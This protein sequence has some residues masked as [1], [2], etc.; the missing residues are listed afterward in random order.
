MTT[1]WFTAAA[2]VVLLSAGVAG[3]STTA[4]AT[5]NGGADSTTA[6]GVDKSRALVQLVGDPI[7]TA[8]K[9]KPAQG[10]KIDWAGQN[11]RSYRAELSARRNEFKRWLRANAPK[12][13][14]TGE[15]DTSL[16]A[17]S[18]ELNGTSLDVLRGSPLAARVEFQGVYSPTIDDPD[19]AII[20]A[21]DA[22]AASGGSAAAGTGIKV[23][24]VDTGIDVGHSCFDDLGYADVPEFGDTTFTNNK[25]IVARVFNNRAKSMQYT[26]EAIGDHGTHVAGTIACNYQTPATVNGVT[27][28]YGIS[29]VAPHALLGNY[30]VFP[31]NVEDAR[32][33]DILNALDAAVS[34]G[35]D[36]INMSLGGGSHG[37]QDLLT[38]AV[39]NIDRANIVVAVSAGNEGPGYDTVG[40]PGMAARALT[41][42]ASTVPHFVGAT[43][44][45]GS[46]DYAIASGDFAVVAADTTAVLA[47][48]EGGTADTDG[49]GKACDP[50][51]AN[52]TGKIAVVSRGSCSF[53]TKVR[54]A[55]GAGAA[56]V[57]VVN[58]VAGD[59]TAMGSDGTPDQPT[60]PA[61]M[62]AL[63]GRPALALSGN[64]S[65]TISL[66]LA[67]QSTTSVDIMAGFSSQGPTDVDRRVKPDVVGPGVNVLSSIPRSY[68][69]GEECFAFFSGTS[70]SSPH[71]AG[72][73]AVVRQQHPLWPA[74]QVRS[75]IV[76]TADEGQLTSYKDGSTLVSDPNIVGAGREN[77]LSAV[78]ATVLLDPVSVS[79]GRIPSGSGQSRSATITVTNTTGLPLTAAINGPSSTKFTTTP[80][81]VGA[82][83]T[84]TVTG[85]SAKGQAAG[86]YWAT[87]RISKAGGA[88]LAHAVLF[89]EVG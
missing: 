52:L 42:G 84:V 6:S 53:S 77:L 69:G 15:F 67:Y 64:S 37:I 73:A 26:A 10:K 59:P 54:N 44:T 78:K 11:V 55:Q 68:C 56:A 58:N 8:A 32:S 5:P 88:E 13:K 74:A 47:I 81:P 50:L 83:V 19:L 41:S 22:W 86:K 36:V 25:V 75:A 65:G 17:V 72:S 60:I 87:L 27:I 57:I 29:G 80:I 30:N 66:A 2:S 45:V 63:V 61:Y 40:S 71:L 28:P 33:E 62:A 16:N 9:T 48:A 14:V 24:V 35:M 39:D 85:A 4:S 23:G 38:V 20:S 18:L 43:L 49:I 7:T 46:N 76:N 70:M 3:M 82:T 12:A 79:F 31:N 21:V 1:R 89:Y 34:D 51:T